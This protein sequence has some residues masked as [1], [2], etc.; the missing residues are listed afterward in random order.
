MTL[1]TIP[2]II[3]NQDVRTNLTFEVS[4][5]GT[6]VLVHHSSSAAVAEAEAAVKSSQTAFL[7]WSKSKPGVRRTVLLRVAELM[8]QRREELLGYMVTETS[9]ER[10]FAEFTIT[11]GINLVTDVA[12]K[13]SSINGYS[14]MLAGDATAIVYKEPYGVILGVAPW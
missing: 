8:E 1:S 14:P 9:A 2:L 10:Q 5:P 6:G 11:A 4:N 7:S 13:V 3:D 12:G